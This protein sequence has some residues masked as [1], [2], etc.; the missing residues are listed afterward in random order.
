MARKV[1]PEPDSPVLDVPESERRL[2]EDSGETDSLII[3]PQTSSSSSSSSSSTSV[4]A[5]A[6]PDIP[7]HQSQAQ[8][9]V[10]QGDVDSEILQIGNVVQDDV[11]RIKDTYKRP[12]QAIFNM[13]EAVILKANFT[14]ETIHAFVTQ[15][16]SP[17][18]NLEWH[19]VILAP[20]LLR[21]RLRLQ[22]VSVITL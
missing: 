2:G 10:G 14:P 9:L 7:A 19:Q 18:C 20:A 16:E 11:P 17:S 12:V 15:S 6:I 22:N 13:A 4:A 1:R 3:E 5:A 21:I 8:L